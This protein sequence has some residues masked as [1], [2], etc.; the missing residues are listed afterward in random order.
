MRASSDGHRRGEKKEDKMNDRCVHS[1]IY[2]YPTDQCIWLI[3]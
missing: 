3:D 1:V 2:H